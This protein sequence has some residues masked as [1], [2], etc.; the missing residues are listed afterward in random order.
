MVAI[1]TLISTNIYSKGLSVDKKAPLNHS[2]EQLERILEKQRGEC[3]AKIEYYAN[4]H[5]DNI[6]NK[7]WS[8]S[9]LDEF[10]YKIVK[11]AI[12]EFNSVVPNEDSSNEK[13]KLELDFD[14]RE[15]TDVDK[16]TIQVTNLTITWLNRIKRKY[17]GLVRDYYKSNSFGNSSLTPEQK[18]KISLNNF[19]PKKH[20]EEEIN[21]KLCKLLREYIA[22]KYKSE[23]Y[24]TVFT[25]KQIFST[26]SR[27]YISYPS[28]F[29]RITDE[30]VYEV[31]KLN[32]K[33][34]VK[35]KIHGSEEY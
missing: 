35:C 4:Q 1:F 15:T 20:N 32:G 14:E 28:E 6:I 29:K 13:F 24:S 7:R 22:D 23:G 17:E 5:K 34:F 27:F 31:G 12:N 16:W 11:P 25:D 9:D 33:I 3:K 26:D 2:L 21:N 8:K 10:E 18:Y 19:K 30:C